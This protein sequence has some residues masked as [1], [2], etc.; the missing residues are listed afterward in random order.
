MVCVGRVRWCVGGCFELRLSV[1]CVRACVSVQ[2]SVGSGVW[3][4][5]LLVE[6]AAV[7]V[8]WVCV[9]VWLAGLCVF[10]VGALVK[11]GCGSELCCGV[12]VGVKWCCLWVFC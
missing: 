1:P 2:Q 8:G 12:V 10:V 11:C 7:C 3:L 4:V 6:R 9:C 5:F